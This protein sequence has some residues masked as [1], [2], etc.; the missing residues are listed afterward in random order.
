M[1][2]KLFDDKTKITNNI[3]KLI[4]SYK[5]LNIEQTVAAM[6]TDG[7]AEAEIRATLASQNYTKADIAQAMTIKKSNVAKQTDISL[8]KLQSAGYA[9]LSVMAK[10]ANIAISAGIGVIVSLLAT[11]FIEW[12]DNVI[13]REEKL[14]ESA[15][16]AKDKIDELNESLS[17]QKKT[18]NEYSEEYAKLAQGVNLLTNQN[19]SLSTEDYERFLE[20]TNI[21]SET[22][23]TLKT[24]IDDN[25][26]AILNLNG[27]VD[28]IIG[29]LNNLIET[30]QRLNNQEIA[31]QLP[32]VY[33][34][35][36]ENYKKIN[37][38]I[39]EESNR[40]KDL[41]QSKETL[42]AMDNFFVGEYD[43][44]YEYI[45]ALDKLG[46][47]YETIIERRNGINGAFYKIE[48]LNTDEDIINK[49]N[50]LFTKSQQQ[51]QNYNSELDTNLS[52]LNQYVSAFLATDFDFIKLDQNIQAG[53]TQ[54]IHNFDIN[55]LPE[56]IDKSNYTEIY[57][58]LKSLYITPIN[59]VS[60]EVREQLSKIF[61]K[62]SD[63]SNVEYIELVD[64]IQ[65]YFNNNKIKINLDFI[66][67]DEKELQNR[68]KNVIKNI[69]NGDNEQTIILNDFLKDKDSSQID[70]FIEVTEGIEGATKA[71]ATYNLAMEKAIEYKVAD[72]S[73]LV[74]GLKE[75]RNAYNT[76]SDAVTQYKES[77]HLTLETVENL[78]SLDKK[79]IKYLYDENGQLA[80]NT[81]AYNALT[82]AKL[83]EMYVN[84]VNDAMDTI[85]SLENEADAAHYLKLKNM[86]LEQSNWDLSKSILAKTE[87]T[88]SYEEANGN[89]T[90]ARRKAYE[91][92][93]A[94]AQ[95]EVNLLKEAM[96]GMKF[97]DF[98]D[99]SKA[100][101]KDKKDFSKE[102]DWIANSVENV[103]D[104][105]EE[106]NDKLNN[107]NG[108][109]KRLSIYDELIKKDQTLIDTTKKAAS[110]YENEW[111]KAS[112][113][114][115]SKYKDKIVSGKYFNIETITDETL[116]NNIEN[117][118][119]IYDKW[120]SM[121]KKYNDA[122]N[123]KVEDK[124]GKIQVQL[125][126][127]EAKLDIH[128]VNNQ[129]DMTSV[130]KNK[131]IKEE[132]LIKKNILDYNL[133]LAKTEAEK[134]ILQKEYND[135]LKENQDLIYENNKQERDNKISYYDSRVKDFQNMIELADSKNKQGTEE[136]YKIINDYLEKEKVLERKNYEEALKMRDN[137]TYGTSEWDK[138]NQEIQ[139]AQDNIYELTIAQIENNRTIL[140]LPIQK[141]EETN[142]KLQEQL[143]L[144]NKTKENLESSIS[145]ASNIVQSQIDTLNEQ[146]NATIDYWDAQIEAINEQKDALT[147]ANEEIKNQLALEKAQYE[148]EKAKSQK[149]VKIYREGEGF[150]FESDQE[151]VKNAKEELDN[152][153]YNSEIHRLDTELDLLNKSKE[154]AIKAIEDQINSLELYKTRIDSITEGYQ[155][156]L[157]LQQLISMFGEDA[158]NKIK[159]GDLSII[160]DIT[161]IYNDTAS[162]ADSLQKQIE[163]NEKAVEQIERYA[164]RWNGSSNTI[165]KAKENIEKVVTDNAKEIE[166]IKDRNDTVHTMVD[167]W[168]ETKL[169][170]EEELGFIK[171]N[172]IVAKDEEGIILGERLENIKKFAEEASNYLNQISYALVQAKNKKDEIDKLAN[173]ANNKVS[174]SNNKT[175]NNKTKS[176]SL[177]VDTMGQKHDGMKSGFV[178]EKDKNKQFKYIALSE[179]KPDEIP[180]VLQKGE[181][182]LNSEQQKTILDNMK[183][184]FVSGMNIG[185]NKDINIP[186]LKSKTESINKTFEF[187]GDIV[188]QNVQDVNGLAKKIKSD[189][190]I[191]LDQEF[192]K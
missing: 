98:Y 26:N 175:N 74:D 158:V 106:L 176:L 133:K 11:G 19:L 60:G 59:K 29:S 50:E 192:Y 189:F 63:I 131:Y 143:D 99:S 172:Q 47:E 70:F 23:P 17:N 7:I 122:V 164:D 150:V 179:L 116:A 181:V 124:R 6:R 161:S 159:N 39:E 142:E 151:A 61:N 79:Y 72:V 65:S 125:E 120:Q 94:D 34:E 3:D 24:R 53:L 147:K 191:R 171:D 43:K 77:K 28:T 139:E 166:S 149:S 97:D 154:E 38:K 157:E 33:E 184:S 137:A 10:A 49:Y 8:T 119:S 138:Y 132:E 160:D 187:N 35:Y 101:K 93:I 40:Q 78:L 95:K 73:E 156:M 177:N 109:K 144:L 56:N 162:Q 82:Q 16:T 25:G 167:A 37:K 127:E 67:E 152:Q 48:G 75:I 81:E 128:T 140:K 42:L 180:F 173:E 18:I 114:I 100:S 15:Q 30:Q 168:T 20:L 55:T 58:Y 86:E 21:L 45:Q 182:I 80:L 136:Q 148:F 108:F 5:N 145:A 117:A 92:I 27:N 76:V 85:N 190:L 9:T 69:T 174:N 155:N 83:N 89:K 121:I 36:Y 188:L 110:A 153:K 103:S 169:K 178:G 165:Q 163:A 62:P 41:Y 1:I 4:E 104:S 102:F 31:D 88:L 134:I 112:S 146:K 2:L 12:L 87:A 183:N 113:K 170:L 84:I 96:N 54:L 68:L 118:Q 52:E 123:Q 135:Y 90:G 64:D 115:G 32:T 105:I 130:D 22:F 107:T 185:F 14:S 186:T 111:L 126:L 91:D 66:V 51:I 46:F 71:I 129:D 57:N 141:I 13:N 44:Q